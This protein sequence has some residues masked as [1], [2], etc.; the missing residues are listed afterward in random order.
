MH[1]LVRLTNVASVDGTNEIVVI[2][3]VMRREKKLTQ[4]NT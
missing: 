3:I 1:V 2:H 4:K